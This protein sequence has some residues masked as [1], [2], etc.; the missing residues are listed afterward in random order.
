[1]NKS[2]KEIIENFSSKFP[3]GKFNS[4]QQDHFGCDFEISGNDVVM[5]FETQ[6]V[7]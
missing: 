5:A 2:L 6:R 1:M 4:N 7:V 3:Q